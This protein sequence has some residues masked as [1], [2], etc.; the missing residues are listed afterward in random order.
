MLVFGRC[1][2]VFAVVVVVVFVMVVF[3]VVGC[4]WLLL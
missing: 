2:A 4:F 3:F 1:F